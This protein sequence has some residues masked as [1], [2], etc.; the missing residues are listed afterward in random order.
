M[1]LDWCSYGRL[2]RACRREKVLLLTA[3]VA[4]LGKLYKS[5]PFDTLIIPCIAYFLAWIVPGASF[6]AD[7][8]PRRTGVLLG[9]TIAALVG[10]LLLLW[11]MQ[12]IPRE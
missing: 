6:A 9:G 2:L 5:I 3:N 7:F 1:V 8:W 12:P 10:G 4:T 11:L